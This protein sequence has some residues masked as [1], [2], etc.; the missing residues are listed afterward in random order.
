MAS[1]KSSSGAGDVH[2]DHLAAQQDHAVWLEDLSRWRSEYRNALMDF[3]RRVAPDLE[4]ENYEAA[5]ER[6]EAAILAH[7]DLLHSHEEAVGFSRR[8][9]EGTT[10]EYEMVHAQLDSRH[11]RS[12]E[13]HRQLA[14][15]HQAILRAMQMM[16]REL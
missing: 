13:A 15:T 10:D 11:R 1:N 16:A 14:R 5:L 9:G 3:A 6:H 2:S 8:L 12:A 4:L 7:E